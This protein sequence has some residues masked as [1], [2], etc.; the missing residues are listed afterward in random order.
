VCATDAGL[1]RRVDIDVQELGGHARVDRRPAV[2]DRTRCIVLLAVLPA[3]HI[4]GRSVVR[5]RVDGTERSAV[6]AVMHATRV[7]APQE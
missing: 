7:E 2:C 5:V 6:A 3:D 1:R 4:L